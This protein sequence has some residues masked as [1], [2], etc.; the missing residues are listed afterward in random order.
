MVSVTALAVPLGAEQQLQSHSWRAKVPLCRITG[1]LGSTN[2]P[3]ERAAPPS[4]LPPQH[5]SSDDRAGPG[6]SYLRVSLV[7]KFLGA[8][9]HSQRHPRRPDVDFKA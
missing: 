5:K 2:P 7:M 4:Q 8:P 9:G 1:I 3:T 6:L